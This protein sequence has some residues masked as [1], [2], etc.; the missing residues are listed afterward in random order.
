VPTWAQALDDLRLLQSGHDGF[1]LTVGA[2]LLVRLPPGIR[3]SAGTATLSR[4]TLPLLREL[5]TQGALV[6]DS[7]ELD[8]QIAT[9]RVTEAVGGL[10]V[11]AGARSDL[12]RAASWALAAAHRPKRTPAIR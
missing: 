9:V 12:V 8:E 2:S 5:C 11:V 3:G 6:H 4:S 1:R 7:P 10:A